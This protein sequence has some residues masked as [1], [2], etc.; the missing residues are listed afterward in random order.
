M[1]LV[2]EAWSTAEEAKKRAA[3]F[4]VKGMPYQIHQCK[5][6]TWVNRV[7][8]GNSDTAYDPTDSEIFVTIA[9]A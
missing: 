5:N 2:I 8:G 6:A 7:L 4:Q 1:N 3:F 9:Q